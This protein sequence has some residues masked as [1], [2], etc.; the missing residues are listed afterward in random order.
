MSL[1]NF[2]NGISSF[3]F[4]LIG[5]GPVMTTGSVWF[6]N[7]VTGI[8]ASGRGVDPS[9][10]FAT[11]DFAVGQC[12][13]AKGDV[14]FV[15]PGHVETITAAAGLAVDV[16]GIS[17][18]GIGAG[19]NRPTI[20]FTTSTAATC[21]VSAANCLMRNILF[22]GGIDALVSPVVVSAADFTLED[23]EYRDVTGQCTIFLLTTAAAD[24]MR[25]LRFRHDGDSSAGTDSS[26]TLVGG[27]RIVIDGMVA[28]GNFA[29]GII[30]IRTTAT[31]DLEIRNFIGRTRNSVDI[32]VI[33][34]ITGSTGIMGPWIS[35][36]LQ[37]NAANITEALTGAT[38]VYI[39]PINLVN[40]AGESSMFTNITASTDA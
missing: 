5:S 32:L 30:N 12:A 17:I 11:I 19:A 4:P 8:D 26:I 29:V 21:T 25:I 39:Q 24:R 6:V 15:M 31:T 7:S 10:P 33:D 36:R 20:N 37:D 13:A 16:V 22:T 28:D 34:T 2:P 38:F 23:C 3:G 1:T 40:L 18:I 14:I 35:G 27:D 9:R